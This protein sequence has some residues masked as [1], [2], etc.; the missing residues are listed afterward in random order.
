[1]NAKKVFFAALL[2]MC[3][4]WCTVEAQGVNPPSTTPAPIPPEDA[5]AAPAGAAVQ[6][7]GTGLSSWIT[8]DR[9]DCCIGK[10]GG[11][12]V[13][14]EVVFRVGPSFP[15]GGEY[16]SRNLQTGGG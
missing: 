2:G 1:M 4:S 12:P 9:H 16:F 14:T 8:Y 13:L 6:E 3:W 7:G 10:G 11:M 5:V 15:V